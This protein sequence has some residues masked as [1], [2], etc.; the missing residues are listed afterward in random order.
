MIQ[1]G[2]SRYPLY[3]GETV[4]ILGLSEDSNE[5]DIGGVYHHCG[6]INVSRALR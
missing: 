2:E 4:I 3:K 1:T 5:C 6:G